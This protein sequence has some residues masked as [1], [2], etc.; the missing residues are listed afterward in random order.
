MRLS[1]WGSRKQ[2]PPDKKI[3]PPLGVSQTESPPE[4]PPPLSS[5]GDSVCEAPTRTTALAG[6]VVCE[7]FSL[8]YSVRSMPYMPCIES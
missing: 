3:P 8:A 1:A 6:Y 4:K 7:S 2:D 5:G